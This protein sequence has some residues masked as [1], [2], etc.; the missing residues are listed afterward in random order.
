MRALLLALFLIIPQLAAASDYQPPSQ[1]FDR[2][3]FYA[4]I[5]GG[6]SWSD[7]TENGLLFPL[8]TNFD[9]DGGI[10]G[11]HLG[12]LQQ[13]GYWVFGI[14][15]DFEWWGVNGDDGS[16]Q[17]VRDGIDGQWL[18]SIRGRL[19]WSHDRLLVYATGGW[20]W[21]NIDITQ[22]SVSPTVSAALN[23]TIDGWTAGGGVEYALND[24]IIL[25]AE[26][27]YMA[28]SDDIRTATTSVTQPKLYSIDD[29][30]TLRGRI[31]FKF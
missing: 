17:G 13:H 7:M 2:T 22:S 6:Q 10:A 8:P 27:R 4:G 3:G 14:E 18:A 24:H 28:I 31:S 15:G 21:G 9:V 25:G 16:A 11:A 19:G 26:Y 1:H 29:F 20:Q 23:Y 30:Q 5:Q 12:Y